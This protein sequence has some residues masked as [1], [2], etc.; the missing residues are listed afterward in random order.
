MTDKEEFAAVRARAYE[1]ADTGR[2]A[3]WAALSAELLAEG[4]PERFVKSLGADALTQVM[5]RNCIAQARER[6]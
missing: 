4:R 6:L 3:D 1:I 2:C 5:L